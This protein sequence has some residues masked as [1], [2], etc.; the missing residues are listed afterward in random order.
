MLNVYSE[1]AMQFF[2]AGEIGKGWEDCE[3]WCHERASFSRQADA[4]AEISTKE[5]YVGWTKDLLG[6]IPDGHYD[7]KVGGGST[8]RAAS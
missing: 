1:S 3:Q 6:P 7:L 4:L 5:G 2:N 8:R